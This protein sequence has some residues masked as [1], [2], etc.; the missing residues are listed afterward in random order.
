MSNF[1]V[2][3]PFLFLLVLVIFKLAKPKENPLK[4]GRFWRIYFLTIVVA[5]VLVFIAMY[6]WLGKGDRIS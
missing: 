4:S 1:F 6:Y 5:T 2:L 3:Y